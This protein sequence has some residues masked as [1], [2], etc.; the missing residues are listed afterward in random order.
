MALR[1]ELERH[2]PV[3]CVILASP[4]RGNAFGPQDFARLATVFEQAWADVGTR[5]LVLTG[6]GKQFSAGADIGDLGAVGDADMA[7]LVAEQTERIATVF[8][9]SPVPTVVAVNGSVAGAACGLVLMADI[10][11]ASDN[12]RL[13][14]PFARLGLVPDTGLSRL[15]AQ[16]I[17]AARAR[18]ILFEGGSI[19]AA[20]A[21][22][23][24]MLRS[25]HA[26]E[27]LHAEAVACAAGLGAM[28][29]GVHAAMRALL[30]DAAALSAGL[31]RE[32]DAQSVRLRHPETV[33]AIFAAAQAMA[34][35]RH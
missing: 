19:T 10:A 20:D 3:A 15:L 32:A 30:A 23:W 12:A 35:R 8:A 34:S 6:E 1:I 31:G 27:S 5:A 18:R 25:L 21:L 4:E 26:P 9:M 17:G 7:A 33:A 2:G 24:G 16:Q 14:F 28:P 29:S 13:L 11:V 22:E